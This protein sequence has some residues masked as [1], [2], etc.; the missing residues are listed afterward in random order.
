MSEYFDRIIAKSQPHDVFELTWS[1]Y[2]SREFGETFLPK[3]LRIAKDGLNIYDG[4][5][6]FQNLRFSK[7]R[8]LIIDSNLVMQSICYTYPVGAA[9]SYSIANLRLK[10]SEFITFIQIDNSD[11]LEIHFKFGNEIRQALNDFF[12]NDKSFT[13]SKLEQNKLVLTKSEFAYF[14]RNGFSQFDLMDFAFKSNKLD[15]NEF[16][17][18]SINKLYAKIP[19][20]N[21]RTFPENDELDFDAGLVDLNKFPDAWSHGRIEAVALEAAGF[22]KTEGRQIY[23]GNWL[24]D[25][26]S[27]V[28][29]GNIGFSGNN[30]KILS[31]AFSDKKVVQENIDTII[32]KPT[33]EGLVKIISLYGAKQFFYD[34]EITPTSNFPDHEQKFEREF[35]KLTKNILGVYRPEEHIDNPKGLTNESW[36]GHDD[37][38]PAVVVTKKSSDGNVVRQTLYAGTS[39]SG[40]ELDVS[41]ENMMKNYIKTNGPIAKTREGLP[42]EFRLSAFGFL[43]EQLRIA[44]S[45]SVDLNLTESARLRH[46][47]AA[48]HVFE[49]YFAHTN[50]VELALIK[51]A[52]AIRDK[53]QM[54]KLEG[55]PIAEMEPET[56][57]NSIL[58]IFPWVE[59]ASVGI[60]DQT[61]ASGIDKINLIPIVTGTFGSEDVKASMANKLAGMILP[62][63]GR[64]PEPRKLRERTMSDRLILTLLSDYASQEREMPY[65]AKTK[66][67]MFEYTYEDFLGMYVAFLDYIDEYDTV[68]TIANAYV[69]PLLPKWF[70]RTRDWVGDEL[71][72]LIDSA[73]F[74]ANFAV[75]V[76]LKGFAQDIKESQPLNFGT[77][78]THTQI[79]KDSVSHPLN[80]L[81]GLMAVEAVKDIGE[82]MKKHWNSPTKVSI[83]SIIERINAI[84]FVH[85]SKTDWMD[86]M[87][88]NW[89][90]AKVEVIEEL[91]NSK[92]YHDEHLYPTG[93][94]TGSAL[95]GA[96]K[97]K[98]K[99]K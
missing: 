42:D 49:D 93:Y 52:D 85:P 15:I 66:F 88:Q 33:H 62:A 48:L 68:K 72:Q 32:Y 84:Y 46:F 91:K 73:E 20:S 87:I 58:N 90:L 81:A 34:L 4:A 95:D 43:A 92:S 67:T 12:D 13:V 24:R 22:T 69:D 98:I 47:G 11:T 71:K 6:L 19:I 63:N 31:S 45:E 27:L 38:S 51:N 82:M 18:Y 76:L 14:F 29:A 83:D 28:G 56:A 60:N 44:S 23:Y 9:I 2:T 79:A 89:I 35:G 97:V 8:F 64:R 80:S 94:L 39:P 99:R 54:S 96:M 26:S 25:V 59:L 86:E 21:L 74:F 65:A 5:E 7:G 57:F 37:L 16:R 1:E 3:V 41:Q 70:K 61:F 77:D 78:P 30:R 10:Q 55:K 53:I 40:S 17:L 75:D 36:F 50:F